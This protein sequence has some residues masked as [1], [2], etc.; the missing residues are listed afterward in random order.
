Q[1]RTFVRVYL[2]VFLLAALFIENATF[3]FFAE[4]D[5]R[6]NDI[7]LNYLDYPK[8]VFG[9]IWTTYKLKL[10]VATIMMAVAGYLFWT[11]TRNT[12]KVVFEIKWPFRL[13]MLLPLVAVLF[14]GIRSSFSH[15]A[16]NISLAVYTDSHVVNEITKNS[17]YSIGYAYYSQK[18]HG[19][20]MSKY[21]KMPLDE[22]YE[23]VSRQLR[24]PVGN[25]EEPF[26][27]TQKTHFPAA[28]PKNLVIFLQESLGAQ[29]VG[30]LGG[31][32]GVT[33]NIDR[34]ANDSLFFDHLYS[35]GTRSVR[36]IAG[37]VSGF[38]PVPGEGVVKRNKSQEGFFTVASLLKPYGYRS[39]FIYG[40][41]SNFD[42][43]R[44]WFY[45]NGFDVL[46]DQPKFKDP[47]FT[48][49]W[50]VCDEDLVVRANEE[51]AKWHAEG[52]PFVSV[53]FSTTNHTPFEFP[54][55]RINLIPGKPKSSVENAIKFADYAIGKLIDD[56]KREGYYDDTV[57]M[58][59]ADHNVRTYGD[60]LVPVPK[61]R[62]MGMILGGGIKPQR[63]AKRSTQ[64]DVL[65]TALDAVGIDLTYPVLGKS[66]FEDPEKEMVLMQFHDMYA[67]RNG[68]KLAVAQPDTPP[69][70]FHLSA[71]EHLT[72]TE[73]DPELERDTMAFIH[74]INDLYQN[75][76]FKSAPGSAE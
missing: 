36:G 1:V 37:S 76:L 2:L 66:I 17:L 25:M 44:G 26:L 34:L 14:I 49:I 59:L 43:M 47:A 40:G 24:I 11:L 75:K 70:T 50:G 65:A 32:K 8:E 9:N 51:F 69:L 57:F 63:V 7:F 41:A 54:G 64:P 62:I 22:A 48:G 21:G 42:N 19:V 71:E 31:E 53:L 16:A 15:R 30:A 74:V 12:F 68:D 20:V 46:I 67:L 52:K 72:P 23:R 6:P 33:P 27:R 73:H 28:K 10:L 61:Y 35:N 3:P 5:V 18:K 29:F 55:G 39:S 45:G 60:D 38:L 58:I 56:A 4:F 13:L